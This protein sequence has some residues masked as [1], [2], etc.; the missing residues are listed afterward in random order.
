MVLSHGMLLL[1][2]DVLE[3]IFQ[4]LGFAAGTIPTSNAGSR[5]GLVL[6][7]SRLS[8]TENNSGMPDVRSS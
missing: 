8:S 4:H 6:H 2:N 7:G 1:P 3:R 5:T